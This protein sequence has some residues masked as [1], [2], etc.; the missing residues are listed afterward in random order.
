MAVKNE[1]CAE[2]RIALG[3]ESFATAEGQ[4]AREQRF[5]GQKGII[6]GAGHRTLQRFA[7]HMLRFKVGRGVARS[8]PARREVRP[9]GVARSLNFK[10]DP[11]PTGTVGNLEESA[12]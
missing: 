6:H 11:P 5:A 10:M 8:L 2:D 1:D 9:G 4:A 7:V 3:F 12:A